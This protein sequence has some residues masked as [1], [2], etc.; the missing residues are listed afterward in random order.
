MFCTINGC[1]FQSQKI[2]DDFEKEFDPTVDR[3]ISLKDFHQFPLIIKG[4]S[5]KD[6][7]RISNEKF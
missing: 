5:H 2:S 3:C 1:A 4:F 6:C 7:S